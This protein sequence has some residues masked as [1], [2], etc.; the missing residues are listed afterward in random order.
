MTTTLL[1]RTASAALVGALAVT[2]TVAVAP[3]A[4]IAHADEQSDRAGRYLQLVN[5]MNHRMALEEHLAAWQYLSTYDTVITTGENQRQHDLA[6]TEAWNQG[7]DATAVH[8]ISDDLITASDSFGQR[9]LD[10]WFA[11]KGQSPATAPDVEHLSTEWDA[12]TRAIVGDIRALDQDRYLASCPQDLANA[13]GKATEVPELIAQNGMF[14]STATP[15]ATSLQHIC[16][17][18]TSVNWSLIGM[19]AGLAVVGTTALFLF[20]LAAAALLL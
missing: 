20:F 5:D 11:G 12:N 18:D 17:K 2:L 15:Q 6:A 8:Q 10:G 3:T 9:L 19:T 7:A 14:D 13:L 16:T 4:N 1:A